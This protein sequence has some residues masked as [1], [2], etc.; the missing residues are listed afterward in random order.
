MSLELTDE[1]RALVNGALESGNPMLLA[2]IT[3]DGKPRMSFRGSIQA[4]GSSQLGFWGRRAEGETMEGL[5]VNPNVA[6]MYRDAANRILLQ[7]A[8]RAR[9]AAAG[10]ERDKV[11]DSAPERERNA[12]PERKG[13][14][15]VIDLDRVEGMLGLTAE[16]KPD[17]VRLEA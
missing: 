12:D 16:G 15:V 6:L 13:E 9:I 3:A 7:F 5:K 4:L 14:G 2:V 10:A 8:G 17:F 11:Y 1:I